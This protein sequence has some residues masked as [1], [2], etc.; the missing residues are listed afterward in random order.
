MMTIK[1]FHPPITMTNNR[2]TKLINIRTTGDAYSCQMTFGYG[3]YIA[4]TRKEM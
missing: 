4:K 2:K 3:I 1:Q